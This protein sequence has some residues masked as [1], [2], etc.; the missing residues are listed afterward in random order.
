MTILKTWICRGT[1][2]IRLKD[3]IKTIKD[4]D[5]INIHIDIKEA[6]NDYDRDP[7]FLR[8]LIDP[9]IKHGINIGG[10]NYNIFFIHHDQVD[11]G[12]CFYISI[13]DEYIAVYDRCKSL[14]INIDY[15]KLNPYAIRFY[16][17][18]ESLAINVF[19]AND[20]CG[21]CSRKDLNLVD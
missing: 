13:V 15:D 8:E 20:D 3:F 17:P 21:C 10:K 1:E 19:I 2:A 7:D 5:I 6:I 9:L 11:D 4:S 12:D 16:E 14:D 18:F